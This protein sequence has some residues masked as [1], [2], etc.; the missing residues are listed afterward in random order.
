MLG[1]LTELGF[2]GLAGYAGVVLLLYLLQRRLL[3]LPTAEHITPQVS[4]S[5]F[6]LA[7]DKADTSTYHK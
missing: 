5:D 4:P 3:F 2:A 1:A 7:Q 6:T